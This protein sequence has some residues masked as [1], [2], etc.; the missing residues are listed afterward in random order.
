MLAQRLN[1]APVKKIQRFVVPASDRTIG[2]SGIPVR[3][4]SGESSTQPAPSRA[5]P[6]QAEWRQQELG[7]A[8][9]VDLNVQ[10]KSLHKSGKGVVRRG[11]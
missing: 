7:I 10:N 2:L 9:R 6:R 8:Q 5:C 11:P 3:E 4:R 1:P